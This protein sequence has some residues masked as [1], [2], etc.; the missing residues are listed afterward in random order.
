VR[1]GAGNLIANAATLPRFAST[2]SPT[3]GRLVIDQTRL[4]GRFDFQMHWAPTPT[5][6]DLPESIVDMSGKTLAPDPSAPSL[7]TAIQEQLGLKLESGR[8]P[9]EVLVIDHAERPSAN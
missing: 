6:S 9:E 7:F 4:A 2:I 8:A 3:L 1:I 5:E